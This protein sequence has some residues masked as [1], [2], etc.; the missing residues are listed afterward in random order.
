MRTP[1]L[2]RVFLGLTLLGLGGCEKPPEPIVRY[3]VA[4]TAAPR[5]ARSLS[6]QVPPG[7]NELSGDALVRTRGGIRV[8]LE[9][10]F[11][12]QE[13]EQNAAT[14]VTKLPGSPEML[15]A[16]V[17]R[18][19]GQLKLSDWTAEQMKKELQEIQVGGT[20]AHSMDLIGPESAGADRQRT[21]GVIVPRGKELWFIKFT[22]PPDLVGRQKAAFETFVKS[23][24]FAEGTGGT[25][26]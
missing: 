18:W 12:V 2:L 9:A 25:H 13:G 6:Y 23:V 20:S 1:R 14:E 26:G 11:R 19:R 15:L 17:N 8:Q 16:N 5:P 24:R 3:T 4:R 22:G 21:L 10:A 7:W